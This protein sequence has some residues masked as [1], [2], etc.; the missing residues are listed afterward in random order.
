MSSETWRPFCLSLNVLNIACSFLVHLISSFHCVL[1]DAS[2]VVATCNNFP[3]VWNNI[4][5]IGSLLKV[6]IHCWQGDELSAQNGIADSLG[7]L[8]LNDGVAWKINKTFGFIVNEMN[9]VN[10]MF[11]FD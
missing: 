6:T 9:Y 11:A 7:F 5:C 10:K 4:A 2:V 1:T 8:F 3:I